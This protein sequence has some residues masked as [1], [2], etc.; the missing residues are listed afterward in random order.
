[1]TVYQADVQWPEHLQS[2]SPKLLLRNLVFFIASKL[3]ANTARIFTLNT[4]V[5]SQPSFTLSRLT[6][7]EMLKK[8]IQQTK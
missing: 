7:H 8:N 2:N 6:H 4:A 5:H 1:M 3:K